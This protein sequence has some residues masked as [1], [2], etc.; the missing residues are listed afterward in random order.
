MTKKT[1][2]K[3]LSVAL[4][5]AFIGSLAG[6]PAAVAADNPFS[7]TP[8]SSGYMVGDA[9]EGKCGGEKKEG[10]GKCGGEKK[11]MEGKCGEGKCGG[12]MKEGEGKCGGEKKEMEGKCGE[13][14]CGGNK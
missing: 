2:V 13:G 3:P 6:A 7:M 11:E 9:H 4:G 5:A 10:E 14:K 1:V 8:L 12:A